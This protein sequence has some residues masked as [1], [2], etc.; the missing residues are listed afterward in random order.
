MIGGSSKTRID[1]HLARENLQKPLGLNREER[2]ALKQIESI[3][4]TH[5]FN[6]D[7]S[8][9]K[10]TE[11][12]KLI[13]VYNIKMETSIIPL[14]FIN[15][16][17]KK[18]KAQTMFEIQQGNKY[19]YIISNK[20]ITDKITIVD[21]YQ[22][23]SDREWEI[24]QSYSIKTLE[25]LYTIMLSFVINLQNKQQES[26]YELLN[27]KRTITSLEKQVLQLEQRK[28]REN[29]FNKKVELNKQIRKLMAELEQLRS[30]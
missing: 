17:D 30:E 26:P 12:V 29:Q 10:E 1:N 4:L 14:K 13:Y 16:L 9:L 20:K 21:T 19:T 3:T 24:P 18:T 27:R 22:I 23:E 15:A 11:L 2:A 25:Y 8:G 7:T 6:S 28:N 5:A